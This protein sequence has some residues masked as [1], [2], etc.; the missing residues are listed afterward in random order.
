[1]NPALRDNNLI[2]PGYVGGKPA[3]KLISPFAKK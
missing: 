3:L 1:V 2:R